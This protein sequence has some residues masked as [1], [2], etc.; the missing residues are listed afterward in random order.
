M[1]YRLGPN[2]ESDS[3]GGADGCVNFMDPDNKGLAQCI[4]HSNLQTI[5]E[6]WCDRISLADFIVVSA[7]IVIARLE[8]NY[9]DSDPFHPESMAAR[10]R[11]NLHVGRSTVE[12]CPDNVG[13][14]PNPEAGCD[15]L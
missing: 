12:K 11:D 8:T 13:L 7:E 14:M 4:H 1:D 9:K 5:Y 6:K 3:T 15:G 2:G 10:F